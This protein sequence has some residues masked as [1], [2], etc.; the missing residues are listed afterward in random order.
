MTEGSPGAEGGA[1][2]IIRDVHSVPAND[3]DSSD[4]SLRERVLKVVADKDVRTSASQ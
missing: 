3:L 2:D 4:D 1:G